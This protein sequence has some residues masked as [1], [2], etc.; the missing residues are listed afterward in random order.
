MA[1]GEKSIRVRLTYLAPYFVELLFTIIVPYPALE[2]VVPREHPNIIVFLTVATVIRTVYWRH[3][4]FSP[5]PIRQK[6]KIACFTGNL[7]FTYREFVLKKVFDDDPITKIVMVYT[8]TL[9]L[10]SFLL[11][12]VESVYGACTWR[13]GASTGNA[14]NV[15]CY[16]LTW[17]DSMWVVTT[18]FLSTGYGGLLPR[19]PAGQIIVSVATFAMKFVSALFFSIIIK[20]NKFSAMEA[21][22]HSFL[23]RMELNERKDLIAVMAVQATF[24]FNKSY[25][26]SLIWHQQDQSRLYFRPL[27]ARLPNEVKKKLYVSRFQASLKDMMKY[28]TDGDLLNTFTKHV[29]VIT[30]AL[31][32]SYVKMVSLKKVYYHKSRVLED[33]RRRAQQATS[34]ATMLLPTAAE[35]SKGGD[36]S[37]GREVISSMRGLGILARFKTFQG[38]GSAAYRDASAIVSHANPMLTTRTSQ[39]SPRWQTNLLKKCD[40][41]LHL[42]QKIQTNAQTIK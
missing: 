1:T 9:A 2:H 7:E 8:I 10:A 20:K 18:A 22:A 17:N 23:F 25:K 39:T 16:S 19:S 40:E 15:V 26:Q 33:R 31:G 24:Q 41:T 35:G 37:E 6:E 36:Y 38:L 13:H 29:E 21:R 5:Y 28:N 34:R 30:A 42:L 3:L 12:V 14:E 11:H 27:S 32:I 4:L